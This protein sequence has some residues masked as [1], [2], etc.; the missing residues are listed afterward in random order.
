MLTD[1]K[2]RVKKSLGLEVTHWFDVNDVEDATDRRMETDHLGTPLFHATEHEQERH[3]GAGDRVGVNDSFDKVSELRIARDPVD[4][5][6]DQK[7][8]GHAGRLEF[9]DR[10]SQE[11]KQSFGPGDP[12][13]IVLDSFFVDVDAK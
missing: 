10:F 3:G 6:E 1:P 12:K 8:S 4:L 5:V 7:Q 9:L 11:G 13:R 2:A